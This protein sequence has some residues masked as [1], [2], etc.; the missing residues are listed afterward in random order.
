[1]VTLEIALKC[2]RHILI[3]S[4]ILRSMREK[5]SYSGQGPEAAQ[6]PEAWEGTDTSL[7][8]PL[9]LQRERPCQAVPGF[10]VG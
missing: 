7:E 10:F 6:S 8:V 2:A 3:L 1:M 5:Y 4:F 9:V